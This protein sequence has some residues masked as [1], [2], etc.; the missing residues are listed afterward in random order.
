MSSPEFNLLVLTA[1]IYLREGYVDCHAEKSGISYPELFDKSKYPHWKICLIS[2][3]G[4]ALK[5]LIIGL[6]DYNILITGSLVISP[7]CDSPVS[8]GPVVENIK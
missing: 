3:G 1:E 2:E 7:L 8:F 4:E 5:K 6:G